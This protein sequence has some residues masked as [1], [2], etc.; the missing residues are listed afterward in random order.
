VL[1]VSLSLFLSCP[2]PR[3]PRILGD[4]M[5]GLRFGREMGMLV[6]GVIRCAMGPVWGR[7][8]GLVS[9]VVFAR[10]GVVMIFFFWG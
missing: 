9:L 6:G 7:R 5:R 2:P 3:P 10:V 4:D 8:S 1:L